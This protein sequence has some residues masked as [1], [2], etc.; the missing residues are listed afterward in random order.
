MFSSLKKFAT[1]LVNKVDD[2]IQRL[3][4][5]DPLLERKKKLD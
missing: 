5:A 2:S 3:E 4:V 1:D